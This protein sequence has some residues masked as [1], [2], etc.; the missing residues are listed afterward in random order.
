MTNWM[1]EN[2]DEEQKD[3]EIDVPLNSDIS[4]AIRTYTLKLFTFGTSGLHNF[5]F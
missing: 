2:R 4:K 1:S 5:I 3:I